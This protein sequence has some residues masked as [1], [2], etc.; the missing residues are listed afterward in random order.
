MEAHPDTLIDRSV[1]QYQITILG[2]L[3]P[4]WSD[5]FAGVEIVAVLTL[6][7]VAVSRLNG[8]FPDQASLRGVLNRLWDLNL[9]VLFIERLPAFKF[10][11][12]SK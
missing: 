1:W 10:G 12:T 3:N 11:I 7:N 2:S 4:D 6:D 5:W 9:T 8:F